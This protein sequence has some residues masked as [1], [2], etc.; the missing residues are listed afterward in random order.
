[1]FVTELPRDAKV[2]AY[3]EGVRR[4]AGAKRKQVCQTAP[5]P[6]AFSILG[7]AED[8]LKPRDLPSQHLDSHVSVLRNVQS[9]VDRLSSVR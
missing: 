5:S 3:A 8:L 1:M 2:R 9:S 4:R 6:Q 7:D